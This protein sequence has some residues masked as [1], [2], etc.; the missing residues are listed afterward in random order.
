MKPV[1]YFSPQYLKQCR[2]VKPGATLRFM[3]NFR[4]LHARGEKPKSKL[5][6]IKIPETL[7]EAF[8]AKAD[9]SG[10]RYQTQIKKLME[11]WLA[12]SR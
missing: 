1:Q 2:A 9:R 7:L 6:S 10:T 3:E 4:K 8:R 11:A 12:N 5:I